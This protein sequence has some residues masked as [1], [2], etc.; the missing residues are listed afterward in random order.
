MSEKLEKCPFC[1]GVASLQCAGIC[2]KH[3]GGSTDYFVSCFNCGASTRRYFETPEEA[4]SAWNRRADH[5]AE[6]NKM[7]PLTLDE[8]REIAECVVT[9]PWVWIEVITPHSKCKDEVSAY[10][11]VQNDYT[12]GRAFCCGYPGMSF[13]FDYADY[14][15]TWLAYRTKPEGTT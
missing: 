8:L 2:V 6:A 13:A 10:Y 12:R 15:K 4:I 9:C 5:I 1:G 11:R 3:D 7:V 14:G